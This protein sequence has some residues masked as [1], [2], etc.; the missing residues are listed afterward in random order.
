MPLP[1]KWMDG[2][3]DERRASDH[4]PSNQIPRTRRA[5]ALPRRFSDPSGNSWGV[6]VPLDAE[7]VRGVAAS[8][9]RTWTVVMYDTKSRTSVQPEDVDEN[10]FALLKAGNLERAAIDEL[11][12]DTID[13]ERNEP[14]E[15]T[16]PDLKKL[17]ERLERCIVMVGKEMARQGGRCF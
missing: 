5:R 12:E 15:E 3:E 17:R 2:G 9:E 1:P 11:I 4:L 7:E 16:L 14:D 10:F 6:A 8:E 13:S